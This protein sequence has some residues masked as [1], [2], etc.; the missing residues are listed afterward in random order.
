MEVIKTHLEGCLVIIPSIYHDDR[1]YFS[2]T[3]NNKAFSSAVGIDVDFVQDNQSF[4]RFGV[5][6]ALHYQIGEYAQAK[7]VRVVSGKVLDVVVDIRKGSKTFGQ[8][9]AMELSAENRKQI[10]IP[11]GFAHGFSVLSETAEFFYKCD[12][13]Y[14]PQHEGGIVYNDPSL[15][16]DWRLNETERIVSAK[17]LALP[18]L[19]NA[20]L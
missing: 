4:S 7:L 11:R 6:R 14:Y 2:E 1:G 3:Y 15:N 5:I 8:H 16:I 10:F 20:L 12:N 19:K 13:Y 18:M 9:F 17:D